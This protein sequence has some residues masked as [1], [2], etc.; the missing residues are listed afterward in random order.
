MNFPFFKTPTAME[1]AKRDLAAAERQLLESR[2]AAEY[3][4]HMVNYYQG[5]V[6]R[7]KKYVE[8]A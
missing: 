6:Q 5:M 2:S 3:H 4:I 7:L 1:L 8:E